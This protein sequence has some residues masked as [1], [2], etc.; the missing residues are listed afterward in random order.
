M[1]FGRGKELNQNPRLVLTHSP[2]CQGNVSANAKFLIP[3][4]TSTRTAQRYSTSK[5][6]LVPL[7]MVTKTT[8]L[9]LSA[10]ES[11]PAIWCR[12]QLGGF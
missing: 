9:Y 7:P 11:V 8:E 5:P 10:N 12:N 2:A 4:P 1:Q 3:G 6:E